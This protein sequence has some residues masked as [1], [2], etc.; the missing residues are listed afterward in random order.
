[1]LALSP[2][3]WIAQPRASPWYLPPSRRIPLS[4]S[5]QRFS[6]ISRLILRLM[7]TSVHDDKQAKPSAF[8]WPCQGGNLSPGPFWLPGAKGN[9]H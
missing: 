6:E 1:M 8:A 9:Q 3:T 2:L 5:F 4:G 7:F